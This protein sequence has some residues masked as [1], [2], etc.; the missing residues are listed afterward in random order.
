MRVGG[1]GKGREEGEG[2]RWGKGG[3][4]VRVSSS[5]GDKTRCY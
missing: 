5:A 2:G 1:R 3:G 4:L